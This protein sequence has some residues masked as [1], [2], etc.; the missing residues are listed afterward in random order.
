MFYNTCEELHTIKQ[1]YLIK[2]GVIVQRGNC[3]HG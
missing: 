2:L 3:P 1:L